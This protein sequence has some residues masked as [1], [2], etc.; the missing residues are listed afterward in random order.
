VAFVVCHVSVVAPPF[1]TDSGFAVSEAVGAVGAGGGGGG[2]GTGF[3]WQAPNIMM[4][5]SAN[6]SVIH[7]VLNCFTFS[8]ELSCAPSAYTRGSSPHDRTVFPVMLRTSWNT[9][10]KVF[11]IRNIQTLQELKNV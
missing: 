7:F 10:D 11:Y 8:S 2:G 3:L 4:A 1:S 6:T 9:F 5:A